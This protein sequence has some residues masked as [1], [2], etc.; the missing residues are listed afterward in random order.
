MKVR[1]NKMAEEIIGSKP[2][3]DALRARIKSDKTLSEQIAGDTICYLNKYFT[4]YKE[5]FPE[6]QDVGLRT[7]DKYFPFAEGGPLYVDEHRG[8]TE[9]RDLDRKKEVMKSLGFRY[10]ILKPGMSLIDAYEALP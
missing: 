10:V 3:L 8:V 1:V 2:S 5:A 7:V 9:L 4:G 6:P